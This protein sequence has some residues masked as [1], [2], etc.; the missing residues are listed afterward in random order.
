MRRVM[1][2]VVL[3]SF[4]IGMTACNDENVLKSHT[5]IDWKAQRKIMLY[6]LRIQITDEKI[7]ENTKTLFKLRSG[8][9]MKHS[10]T[11]NKTP[12]MLTSY[13]IDEDKSARVT[14]I[15]C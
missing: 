11:V 1:Y 12:L 10:A 14:D 3:L 8:K 6:I 15:I 5:F 2:V 9:E 13:S 7:Q 4:V